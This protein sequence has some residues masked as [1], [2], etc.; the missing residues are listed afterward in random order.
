MAAASSTPD[1]KRAAADENGVQQTTQPT[2]TDKNTDHE[3][4]LAKKPRVSGLDVKSYFRKGLFDDADKLR[5]ELNQAQPYRH[6]CIAPFCSEELLQGVRREMMERLHF[7]QKETDIF[8]YHQSGD[9][10]NLDG[11]DAAEKAQL[12]CLRQLRDALYSEEFRA[13]ISSV[14]GCGPLSGTRTDMSTN[15]YKQGDHLL[16]HDDVIGDRCVSYIIYLPDPELND[17]Q[18]WLPSD[19][20]HLEL[21]P[22]EKDGWAPQIRPTRRLPPRW[23]QI[24]FFPVL[25]GESHHSVEEVAGLGKERLSIQGWF[26]FPQPGEPGY[27]A[28]Q[29]QRLWAGGAQSTLSQVAARDQREAGSTG[30]AFTS[31]EQDIS[32]DRIADLSESDVTVLKKYLNPEYLRPQVIELVAER[33]AE[34]SHIQLAALLNQQVASELNKALLEADR[35]DGMNGT[36]IPPHGAGEFGRWRAVGSPVTRRYLRLDAPTGNDD[37]NVES[38]MID[39]TQDDAAAS[40]LGDI[41]DELFG[42]GAF[43]RWLSVITTLAFSGSRG[44]VRRFRSGLDYTLGTPD[45]TTGSTLDAVLCFVDQPGKWADGLVG[46]Y[47]CYVDGGDEDAS[48]DGSVYRLAADDGIL[49][50]APAAWNTLNVALREPGVVRFIKYV[51]ASAPGSRWDVS[52]EY[53]VVNE[54]EEE[55]E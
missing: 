7:T 13:F 39:Q 20:G 3:Q 28:D 47:E 43:A 5:K 50:T 45:G 26:H 25:P 46:G 15:R 51:S 31:Y 19:G 23:N 32:V 55:E 17:G 54:E 53:A 41:R 30:D 37:T 2:A 42:S 48:N 33:F 29:M 35:R 18:G 44:M 1:N 9:L 38:S 14:T 21:Y 27:A 36:A 52:F 24:V 11:L 49:M 16:L 8:K 22:R 34:D 12:P 4:Q 10:A 6:C 40:L